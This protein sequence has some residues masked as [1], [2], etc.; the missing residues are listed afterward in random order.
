MLSTRTGQGS[1]RGSLMGPDCTAPF[2]HIP[3]AFGCQLECATSFCTEGY[4]APSSGMARSVRSASSG[5]RARFTTTHGS[6]AQHASPPRPRL[7]NNL[8][9]PC[10]LMG[11]T[12][13][14]KRSSVSIYQNGKRSSTV[15]PMSETSSEK[16]VRCRSRRIIALQCNDVSTSASGFKWRSGSMAHC[17]I[18]RATCS[19]LLRSAGCGRPWFGYPVQPVVLDDIADTILGFGECTVSLAAYRV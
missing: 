10:R 15:R 6:D 5:M 1:K 3:V 12:G 2:S 9:H 13:K 19:I 4:F 17:M 11:L 18:H 14:P 8:W 7:C 16:L